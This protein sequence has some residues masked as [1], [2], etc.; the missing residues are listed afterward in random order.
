MQRIGGIIQ[1][2]ANGVLYDCKGAFTYNLGR[3]LKSGVA[4]SDR[5]H[6]FKEAPQVPFIAGKI[7]DRA[8]LSVKTLLDLQD[9]TITLTVGNGKTIVLGGA[10]FASEGTIDTEEGEIEVRFEGDSCEEV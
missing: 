2:Q 9:A 4:G 7:T 1:L 3:N 6:G 5:V 8:G 10:C